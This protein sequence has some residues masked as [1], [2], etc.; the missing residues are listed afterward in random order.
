[1]SSPLLGQFQDVLQRL[2][3]L[4]GGMLHIWWSQC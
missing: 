4:T 3:G 1:M 2:P